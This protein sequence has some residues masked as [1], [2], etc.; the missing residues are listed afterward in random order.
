MAGGHIPW[1]YARPNGIR[2]LIG[3][4]WSRLVLEHSFEA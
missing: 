2:V 1:K 3:D 4:Y